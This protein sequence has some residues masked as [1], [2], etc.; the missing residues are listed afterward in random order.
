MKHALSLL[1]LSSTILA[2]DN[3]SSS[4]DQKLPPSIVPRLS[5]DSLKEQKKQRGFVP[6][7]Q[8]ITLKSSPTKARSISDPRLRLS[9]SSSDTR[10][11]LIIPP[12]LHA[13]NTDKQLLKG[14]PPSRPPRQGKFTVGSASCG[15]FPEIPKR[16]SKVILKPRNHYDYIP[17]STTTM[18]QPL[19]QSI[20]IPQKQ[21][22]R[23]QRSL[24]ASATDI[25]KEITQ[26]AP[27]SSWSMKKQ[28]TLL[29]PS[30]RTRRR[31]L[32][33]GSKAFAGHRKRSISITTLPTY[34]SHTP[35]AKN[36]ACSAEAIM[37]DLY[38]LD[39]QLK[40]PEYIADPEKNWRQKRAQAFGSRR[41]SDPTINQDELEIMLKESEDNAKLTAQVA[42]IIKASEEI[43][44]AAGFLVSEFDA[45]TSGKLGESCQ[46]IITMARTLS[47]RQSRLDF[48]EQQVA[49]QSNRI[50]DMANTLNRL[51][52][53]Q[54]ATLERELRNT[55][56][57]KKE[58][59]SKSI[60]SFPSLFGPLSPRSKKT[61]EPASSSAIQ[62]NK[63]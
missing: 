49:Y 60:A 25:V 39:P 45:F 47:E 34:T 1:F 21:G 15:S 51:V 55:D 16:T 53:L 41:L 52:Q 11:S 63:Q 27:S 59:K 5:L 48:L 10:P 37:Q 40:I 4:K 13:K 14:P 2:G 19:A 3:A 46:L 6:G 33:R 42:A 57:D 38:N 24:S 28:S 56:S 30:E 61:S 12:G 20:S 23:R 35:S 36:A 18:T 29:T 8:P 9:T 54:A 44:G 31:Q 17:N 50:E 22:H 62:K 7:S 58:K 43:T 26:R 32:N